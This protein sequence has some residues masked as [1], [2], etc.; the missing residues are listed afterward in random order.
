MPSGHD[1]PSR[2]GLLPP[3]P[4]SPTHRTRAVNRN[5]FSQEWAFEAFLQVRNLRRAR[6][7]RDQLSEHM[8]Q[9]R[10]HMQ[11]CG[12][13]YQIVIKAILSGYFMVRVSAA[14]VCVCVRACVSARE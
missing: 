14:R 10:D 8:D 1:V 4:F 7:V 12:R 2:P 9:Y 5:D 11:S 3:P 13:D 6:D